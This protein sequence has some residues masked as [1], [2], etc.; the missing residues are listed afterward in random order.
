MLTRKTAASLDIENRLDPEESIEGGARYLAY[1]KNQIPEEIKHP[2]RT[3]IALA[4]Y[5]I[6]MGHV[7]D[8]QKLARQLSKNPNVWRDLQTVFPLLEKKQYYQSLTFGYANGE[9]L[10]RNVKRIREYR[11]LM[12][13]YFSKI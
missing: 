7:K 12:E 1:L 8:A 9:N 6:G 4:A 11:T 13:A 3:W 10:V 2:D 5:I